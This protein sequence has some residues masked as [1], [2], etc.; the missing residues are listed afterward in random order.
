LSVAGICIS[1]VSL[2]C[3]DDLSL[4][5]SKAEPCMIMGIITEAKAL[6]GA[7]GNDR[8]RDAVTLTDEEYSDTVQSTQQ[9]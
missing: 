4:F 8:R 3:D 1:N 6:A 7:A 2:N 9:R 5:V